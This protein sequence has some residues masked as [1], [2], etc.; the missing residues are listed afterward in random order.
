[1]RREPYGDVFT[2]ETDETYPAESSVRRFVYCD[3]W[4][5]LAESEVSLGQWDNK[6]R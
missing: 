5:A 3:E 4:M 1:M 2:K 6:Y